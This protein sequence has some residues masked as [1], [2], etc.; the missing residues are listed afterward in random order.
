M[1]S[2]AD[3]NI[4]IPPFSVISAE[5]VDARRI[6][7]MHKT[8]SSFLYRTCQRWHHPFYPFPHKLCGQLRATY[9]CVASPQSGARSVRSW[10]AYLSIYCKMYSAYSPSQNT[11]D[12]SRAFCSAINSPTPPLSPYYTAESS[13]TKPRDMMLCSAEWSYRLPRPKNSLAP[14]LRPRVLCGR[15]YRSV[16]TLPTRDCNLWWVPSGYRRPNMS[17][18]LPRIVANCTP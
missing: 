5:Q 4:R 2:L 18:A 9:R 1:G 16:W 3:V 13:W 6:W 12:P 7:S 17:Q 10:T 8:G 14:L 11:S 15:S